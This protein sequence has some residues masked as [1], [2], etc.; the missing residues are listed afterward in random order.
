[1]LEKIPSSLN[2][3]RY[4]S[5]QSL[6]VS[7]RF[8]AIILTRHKAC[9]SDAFTGVHALATRNHVIKLLLSFSA[10]LRLPIPLHFKNRSINDTWIFR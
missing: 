7:V 9:K 3:L 8:S 4:G 2:R 1:M 10:S 5:L 6:Q